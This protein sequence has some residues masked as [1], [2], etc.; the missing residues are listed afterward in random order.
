MTANGNQIFYDGHPLYTYMGDMQAGQFNGRG[1]DN[2]WY[3]VGI[4]L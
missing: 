3:L 2:A 4:T 1:M